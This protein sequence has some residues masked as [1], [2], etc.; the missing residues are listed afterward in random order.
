[1]DRKAKFLATVQHH[2]AQIR[3]LGICQ[4]G[5]FGSVQRGEDSE[6]SDV[7]VLVD[8]EPGQITFD[9][10][11]ALHELLTGELGCEVELVTTRSLSPVIGPKILETVEYVEIPA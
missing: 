7:D 1:M 4:I 11:Y 5:L 2:A 9:R 3:A 8:F 10:F 6:A